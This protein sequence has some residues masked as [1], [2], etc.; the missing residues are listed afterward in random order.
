MGFR[1]QKRINLGK[2]LGLNISK[3]GISPSIRTK[4]GSI[5]SKGYSVRTRCSWCHL[6]QNIFQKFKRWLRFKPPFLHNILY[7]QLFLLH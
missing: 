4:V 5:S 2:G 1:F 7:L 6:S 3:S